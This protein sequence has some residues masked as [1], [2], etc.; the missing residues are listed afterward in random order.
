MKVR[1]KL[2]FANL[3]LLIIFI[4]YTLLVKNVDTEAIGPG[5]SVVGFSTIN[6]IFHNA[7]GFNSTWYDITKYL[8]IIPF[9]IVAFYGLIG[10]SQLIK[11]KKITKVDKKLIML[12]CFYIL[13]GITY[14]L[15]EKVIINYRPVLFDGELEASYPSSHT[16]LAVCICLSSLLISKN[17]IKNKKV[18]KCFDIG[19]IILMIVLVV[20]RILSGVHWITDIIGGILISLLLVSIF[21]TFI[22]STIKLKPDQKEN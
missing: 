12:G 14:V 5:G 6:G 17:Y 9:L 22:T 16:M 10:V 21:L 8:G 7:L 19:T 18:L 15:F 2:V 13:M 20:G 3:I 4:G 1:K 11:K